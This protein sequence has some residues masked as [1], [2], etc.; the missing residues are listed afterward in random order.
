MSDYFHG[1]QDMFCDLWVTADGGCSELSLQCQDTSAPAG[2]FILNSFGRIHDVS[3]SSPPLP[4]PS[5][6]S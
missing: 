1:P 6:Y 5:C 2:Y 4:P 3:H